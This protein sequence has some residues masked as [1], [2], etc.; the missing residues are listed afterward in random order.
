MSLLV[1]E[2]IGRRYAHD[3][4]K[5]RIHFIYVFDHFTYLFLVALGLSCC[6]AF[7]LVAESGCYSPVA[8][9]GFSWQ[10]LFLLWNTGSRVSELQ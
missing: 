10:L 5:Q 8:V 9:S 2:K 4:G 3:Y 7:S 6:L 1:T